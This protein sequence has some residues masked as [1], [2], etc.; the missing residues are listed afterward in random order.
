MRYSIADP[1]FMKGGEGERGGGVRWAWEKVLD[2]G[3]G[4]FVLQDKGG[5]R[6][7]SWSAT[8]L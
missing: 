5:G 2:T 8:D 3:R 1:E 4:S 6:G 7:S